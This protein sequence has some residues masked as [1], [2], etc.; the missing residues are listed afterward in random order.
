MDLVR[1]S[2]FISKLLIYGCLSTSK[3][4]TRWHSWLGNC[5]TS[6]KV[7]GSIPDSQSFRPHYGRGVYT[8]SNRNEY[9]EYFLGAK[10]GRCLVLTSLPRSCD[11]CLEILEPQP[12]R[13]PCACNRPA[14]VLLYL[15]IHGLYFV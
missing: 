1:S 3:W 9:Q 7:G 5:T 8:T 2:A 15:H 6:R 13:T 10:G 11:D 4:A 12:L 14:Q